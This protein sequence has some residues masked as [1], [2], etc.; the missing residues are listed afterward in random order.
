M[1]RGGWEEALSPSSLFQTEAAIVKFH[2]KSGNH[3]TQG[4]ISA[5]LL[6]HLWRRQTPHHRRGDEH[7]G[8]G[9][10]PPTVALMTTTYRSYGVR[11]LRM[12]EPSKAALQL[13]HCVVCAL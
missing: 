3:E 6:A 13:A 1:L 10:M 7:D 11:E 9:K 12:P 8:Q 2:C 4:R 5:C